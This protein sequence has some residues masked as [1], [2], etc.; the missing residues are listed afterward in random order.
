[1]AFPNYATVAQGDNFTRADENPLSG[2][3]RWSTNAI[4][5]GTL[6]LASNVVYSP[7]PVCGSLFRTRHLTD[8]EAYI[9]LAAQDGNY[10]KQIYLRAAG[11]VGHELDNSYLLDVESGL[12][13]DWT[14]FCKQGNVNQTLVYLGGQAALSNGDSIGFEI[15]GTTLTGYR[16]P[17]AGG[18]ASVLTAQSSIWKHGYA[19][20]TMSNNGATT[21]SINAFA[22]GGVAYSLP[23]DTPFP[24]AGHGAT[25]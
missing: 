1:M 16:K 10:G 7:T 8:S 14:I 19:G 23:S 22:I 11:T 18:W 3:G 4:Y 20:L 25:W 12:P 2:G 5:N 21:P 13:G 17:A 9:T 15:V 24:P 6:R